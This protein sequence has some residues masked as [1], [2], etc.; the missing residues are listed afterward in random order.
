MAQRASPDKLIRDYFYALFPDTARLRIEYPK[1]T[2]FIYLYIPEIN[3]V[4]GEKSQNLDKILKD[5]YDLIN[6]KRKLT[7]ERESKGWA[8]RIK[9]LVDGSEIAQKKK[10]I[11]GRMPLN[12]KD[13]KID[14]GEAI[15]LTRRGVIGVK[16]L[17]YKGHAKGNIALNYGDFGLQAQEGAYISNRVIEAGRKVI[18]PYVKKSGKMWIRIFPHLGKTKKPLELLKEMNKQEIST[19]PKAE[20]KLSK[21]EV[22]V[23]LRSA[24]MVI[25]MK[26]FTGTVISLK[27][28]KTVTV[29][30]IYT[31]LHPKY[32]KPIKRGK[33]YQVHYEPSDF[34][35]KLGDKVKIKSS[36]PYSATKRFLLI[37]KEEKL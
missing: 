26:I 6:D 25:R 7:E 5:I 31:K 35:L 23:K 2:I 10:I 22:L 14:P 21:E 15:A 33:N 1:S 13:S 37:K 32:F 8:I 36:R 4:L 34:S 19:K 12:T 28:V 17:I 20:K 9:G 3:L 16:V 24:L 11:R 29:K 27:N 30:V 18:S